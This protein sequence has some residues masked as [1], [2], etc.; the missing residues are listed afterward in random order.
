MKQELLSHPLDSNVGQGRLHYCNPIKDLTCLK[1]KG[2][3]PWSHVQLPNG[4]LTWMSIADGAW[5]AQGTVNNN[6][7]RPLSILFL[8]QAN[9]RPKSVS[10]CP[11]GTFLIPIS[12]V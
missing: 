11:Q 2:K 1:E 10:I 8:L 4:G 9:S 6:K 7:T 3:C 5:L 12:I